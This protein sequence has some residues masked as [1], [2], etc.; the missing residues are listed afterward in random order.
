MMKNILRIFT[1]FAVLCLLNGTVWGKSVFLSANHHTT[2]F[3]SWAINADGT[4]SYQATYSLVHSTDPAGIGIDAVTATG[5]PIMFITSEFSG[6]VEIVDPVTLTYIGVSSGPSNLAGV[7]VDDKDDIVYVLGRQTNDLYIYSW[8]PV[9]QTLTQVAMIELSGMTYGFGLA[10]DDSRDILWVSDTGSKMVKAYNVNV[11]NWND[12]VEIPTL[13]FSVS[14]SPIDVAVD[15]TRN[16][17]YTVAGW[18]GSNLI[19]RQD[20]LFGVETIVDIGHGAIGIAVDET[21]GYVYITGGGSY[22]SY[23]KDN[24]EVWNCN[25]SPAIMLQA[26]TDLGNPAGLAIANVSYNPL[27]LAKNDN[28]QGGGVSVGS[29]FTYGI[30]FDCPTSDLTGVIITDTLPVELDFISANEGGIYDSDTHSVV[31]D[32]GVI[33]AGDTIPTFTLEVQVNSN[34]TLGSTIHNYCTLDC[35][36]IPPT[37]VIEG[38][39]GEEPGIPV[40]PNIPVYIDIKPESCPNPLNIKCGGVVSVSVLGSEDF[41]VTSI[42][43]CTIALNYEGKSGPAPIRSTYEDVATPFG[44]DLCDCHDLGGDGYMDLTLK[45]DKK[46]LVKKLN[47]KAKELAGE[48]IPL[49]LTGSTDDTPIIGSDCIWILDN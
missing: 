43:P 49:T 42:D 35:D 31:W 41:D 32:I 36:Q 20:I 45:F 5:N 25:V 2:Q 4:V 16:L 46:D 1:V 38:E 21:T 26:T 9:V 30:S 44:G 27:N 7:D 40:L 23:S 47:L 13:S 6:G 10:F 14:H 18:A 17:V 39:G 29:I 37:T 3:D 19:T 11:S 8:D 24:L 33:S 15:S 12:I 48:T 22:G 34:A 28:I